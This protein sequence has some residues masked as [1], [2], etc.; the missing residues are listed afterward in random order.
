MFCP[1]CGV[2]NPDNAM[3]CQECGSK[4]EGLTPSPVIEPQSVPVQATKPLSKAKKLILL[5]LVM[6]CLAVVF[7]YNYGKKIF[8]P[9]KTA[10]LHFLKV[11]NG[12]WEGVYND[13]DL[14]ESEYI[15][16]EN[17]VETQNSMGETL[18][19]AYEVGDADY[20]YGNLGTSVDM[21]YRLKGDT[22]NSNFRVDMNKQAK[23]NLLLFDSWKVDPSPYICN[24]Y[25]VTV[26]A[27]SKVIF[28]G[29]E[30]RSNYITNEDNGWISYNIPQLFHGN[31]D[32]LVTQD[33][34]EDFKA[35]AYTHDGGYTVDYMSLKEEVKEEL[36]REA[37]KSLEDIYKSAFSN[38]PFN[39]IANMFSEHD[40]IRAY[41]EGEY[42]TFINNLGLNNETGLK[43]VEFSNVTGSST[44]DFYDGKNYVYVTL[45]YEYTATSTRKD[46]W[47]SDISINTNSD[48]SNTEFVYVLEN[49]KW[50]LS[51]TSFN[52]I[53]Y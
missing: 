10:E 6:L 7:T 34:M 39:Q 21:S 41:M 5:E 47:T 37:G 23:K 28:N 33:N 50:V 18:I 40:D 51:S 8:S 32:I 46:W 14:V 17:F 15:T 52:R 30:L 12:D 53:Y 4:I 19:N 42:S 48:S 45:Y 1:E 43:K 9:E 38:A 11:M 26:P 22:N 35:L 24:D 27:G 16:K 31:Y 49:G 25:R 44:H 3:F 36:I 2:K 20:N 13:L 29:Q